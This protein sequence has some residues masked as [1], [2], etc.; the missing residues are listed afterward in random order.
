MLSIAVKDTGTGFDHVSA[1]AHTAKLDAP[2]GRGIPLLK[3]VCEEVEYR[4][5][6]NEVEVLFA[7]DQHANTAG[8]PAADQEPP[9]SAA[10]R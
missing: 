2:Y 7:L 8:E 5:C 4:G 3:R 6:G 1:M 9:P 10:Q